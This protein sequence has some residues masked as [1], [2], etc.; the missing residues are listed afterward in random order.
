LQGYSSTE[1]DPILNL[2][3]DQDTSSSTKQET[4]PEEELGDD[5]LP[6]F[7]LDRSDDDGPEDTSFIPALPSFL[8]SDEGPEL[9]IVPFG[10]TPENDS[11]SDSAGDDDDKPDPFIPKLPE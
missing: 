4:S 6:A 5:L 9:E 3:R 11:K 10:T 2:L 8:E 7:L 1:S